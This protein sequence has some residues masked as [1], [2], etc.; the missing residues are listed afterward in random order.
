M[1]PELQ[2]SYSTVDP[3]ELM[4]KVLPEYCI[5][6][7]LECLFW[8]RGANDTYQVRCADGLYFLRVYR[9][10][11]YP[12]DAVEFE[13]EALNYLHQ[14]GF[15][16]AY[17]IARKSG[18]YITEIAACEGP[19]FVLLTALAE[20]STPDY[21]S[22]DNCR[23]VGES[24]AKLHLVSSGFETSYKRTNLD[25]Q[26]LLENSIAVIRNHMAQ[27]ADVIRVFEKVARDAR[28]TVEAVPEETLDR[29]IC[30]GDLHGG[31]LHLHE[32]KVTHFDFE[33]CAFG[34]RV[35]DLAT[36]KWGICMGEQ[37]S[38]RWSAFVEGYESIRPISESDFS[39]VDTFVLIRELAETAYGIR[40]VKDFG[41]ND[42]MAADIDDACD[43][44]KILQKSKVTKTKSSKIKQN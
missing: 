27:H 10:G 43:R 32:G 15:P 41:H 31:N 21:D 44:I 33:E 25:L 19:R 7:P 4:T 8:E 39:L 16:V 42:I 11:A 28:E 9:C 6:S 24:V 3:R 20:G 2:C 17:P 12:R 23:L 34:Y 38:E 13:A 36:F 22:R 35:Y 1:I 30:H 26:W 40:H 14:Q 29:G 18:K 5:D 37:G